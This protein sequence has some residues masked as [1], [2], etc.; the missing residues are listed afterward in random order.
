MNE[1]NCVI[2][3]YSRRQALL[4]G[5]LVDVTPQAVQSGFSVPVAL[6]SAAWECVEVPDGAEG[7]S[8]A[9]RLW[10]VLNML[11]FAI[12]Q[13]RGKDREVEFRVCQENG[14]EGESLVTLKAV[15]GPNDDGGPCLTVML[16]NED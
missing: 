6:T 8:V 14:P 2:F 12:Q 3:A 15:I 7:Q 16:P 9:G 1:N 10:D 13:G 5:V 4:D 11:H